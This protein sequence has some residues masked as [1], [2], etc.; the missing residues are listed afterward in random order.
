[1]Q[2]K[3]LAR[4]VKKLREAAGLSQ[5]ALAVKAGL[6]VSVVSQVEQGKKADPRMSTVLAI[7]EALGVTCDSLTGKRK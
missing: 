6:S 2:E 7:A 5:Q 4:R 3:E 1:M